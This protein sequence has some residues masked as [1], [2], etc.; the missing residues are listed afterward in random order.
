MLAVIKVAVVKIRILPPQLRMLVTTCLQEV[1]SFFCTLKRNCSEI[2]YNGNK[3]R[4]T[5]ITMKYNKKSDY[6]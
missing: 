3:S 6:S 4:R 5:I 1:T 2:N